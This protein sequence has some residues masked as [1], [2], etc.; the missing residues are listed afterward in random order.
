MCIKDRIQLLLVALLVMCGGAMATQAAQ[1]VTV[2]SAENGV[3]KV[4]TVEP[5]AGD[6]VTITVTPAE[7]YCLPKNKLSAEAMVSPQV[8]QAPIRTQAEGPQVG[9]LLDIIGD[10]P[11]DNTT[12]TTY[13]FVM[14]EEPFD[15]LVTAM[16][17]Q[18]GSTGISGTS[19]AKQVA[20]MRYVNVAGQEAQQPFKGVNIVVKVHNDG[21][22]A[23]TKQVF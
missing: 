13:S 7:G 20:A 12:E 1:K 15:V 2:G 6:I 9:Y 14:P 3:V 21:T 16:F 11:S 22:M 19:L 23:V 10:E 8:A 5:G 17:Q 18:S 4:S